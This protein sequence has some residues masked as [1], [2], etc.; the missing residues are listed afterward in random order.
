M[1]RPW[2]DKPNQLY[3]A[4]MNHPPP[5]P[6]HHHHHCP[7]PSSL[8][9]A[10]DKGL[11]ESRSWGAGDGHCAQWLGPPSPFHHV[12]AHLAGPDRGPA[13]RPPRSSGQQLGLSPCSW[14]SATAAVQHIQQLADTQVASTR[15]RPSSGDSH[16]TELVLDYR[17]LSGLFLRLFC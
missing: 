2:R 13:V 5:P 8:Q 11:V 7:L 4:C 9:A 1:E 15:Y 17:T 10:P 3:D 6:H 14:P 12:S 16:A